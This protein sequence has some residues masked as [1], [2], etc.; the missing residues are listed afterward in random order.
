MWPEDTRNLGIAEFYKKSR[1]CYFD[2]KRYELP[3]ISIIGTNR[4]HAIRLLP[5][6]SA[7]LGDRVSFQDMNTHLVT[8]S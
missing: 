8:L 7:K 5:K 3:L 4:I 6:Q 2:I 1:D